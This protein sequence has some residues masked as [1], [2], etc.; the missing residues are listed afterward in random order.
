MAKVQI[1]DSLAKEIQKKFKDESHE[2]VS[3]LESLEE[4]PHKGKPV[5]RAG[6]I[7]IRELKYKKFRFYFIVDGHKLK[8]YSK[9]ELTDLLM[10][11]V[12]MSDKKTQQKTIEEIKKI[13]IKIGKE[14][15]E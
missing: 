12:R 6:G 7:E 13:L 4:N 9:E 15:F 11:F 1:I 8:I 5:G 3:L 14:S 10:K 2:I